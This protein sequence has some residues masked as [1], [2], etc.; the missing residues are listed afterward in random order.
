MAETIG[1][2]TRDNLKS[3]GELHSAVVGL[4]DWLI[5]GSIIA[6]FGGLIVTYLFNERLNR[7]PS[8]EKNSTN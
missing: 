4:A 1:V 3:L 2:Q 6:G 7:R 8:V 5:V